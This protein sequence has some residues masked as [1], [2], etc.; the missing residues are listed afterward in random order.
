M[1]INTI[2]LK[3]WKRLTISLSHFNLIKLIMNLKMYNILLG[4]GSDDWYMSDGEKV[5]E[6]I[7]DKFFMLCILNIEYFNT[8]MLVL[9]LYQ[10]L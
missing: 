5:N 1:Y 4:G 7:S 9:I 3:L 10:H 8:L 2:F 6:G